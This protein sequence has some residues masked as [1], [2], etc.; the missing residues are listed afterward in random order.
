MSMQISLD[1]HGGQPSALWG[2]P[3][4]HCLPYT[5]RKMP[6][7]GWEFGP[8]QPF[9]IFTSCCRI[10]PWGFPRPL[11][12]L[13]LHQGWMGWGD[14]PLCSRS[15][16]YPAGEGEGRKRLRSPLSPCMQPLPLSR[17]NMCRLLTP[18]CSLS[19]VESPFCGLPII[20]PAVVTLIPRWP[21]LLRIFQGQEIPTIYQCYHP[22]STVWIT[23]A[24][25]EDKI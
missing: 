1:F 10:S 23:E 15:A 24:P 18:P 4:W 25:E 13:T 11:W 16:F 8:L 14:C 22:A 5:C 19:P 2:S 20:Q 12:T 9:L 21:V 6:L 17:I 7:S 3:H